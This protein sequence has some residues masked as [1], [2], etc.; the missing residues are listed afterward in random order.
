MS[1][2]GGIQLLLQ[3]EITR[4]RER[5][6]PGAGA[7]AAQTPCWPG[8]ADRLVLFQTQED[9]ETQLD[10]GVPFLKAMRQRTE[11]I[12][13]ETFMKGAFCQRNPTEAEL[14][15]M[16]NEVDTDGNG[17]IGFPEFFTMMARKMKDTDS[18]EEI[19]EAFRVFDKDG[20]GYISTAEL[21]HVMT[22]FGE[23]LTAEE[24][25]EMI[26]EADTDGDGQVNY[27]EFVQIMAAK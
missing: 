18:E 21:H 8:Q 5:A 14:Q 19:H 7:A 4:P 10:S 24:V 9:F 27:E 15:D 23:K 1:R 3:R 16:I 6:A 11:K 17:T 25:D 22:N 13:S 12:G 26:R 2:P 20:N